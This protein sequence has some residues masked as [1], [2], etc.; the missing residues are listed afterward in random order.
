MALSLTGP[1]FSHSKMG[2][3]WDTVQLCTGA[4]R[5]NS[6]GYCHS[7]QYRLLIGWNENGSGGE[8]RSNTLRP[9]YCTLSIHIYK[10]V[11]SLS[12]KFI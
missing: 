7:T 5:I 2:G 8:L 4:M 1:F 6:T 9:V 3:S 11:E 10:H 12:Y